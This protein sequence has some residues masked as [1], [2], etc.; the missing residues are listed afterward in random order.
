MAVAGLLAG[1]GVAIPVGAIGALLISLTVR[2]SLRVGVAAGFGVAT[3]D[4]GYALVAVLFGGALGDVLA[5]VAG[6]M[7]WAAAV[8]LVVI[9]ARTAVVA[10]RPVSSVDSRVVTPGRAYLTLVGLTALNPATIV[11]FGALVL[12]GQASGSSGSPGASGP[13]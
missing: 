3:V 8:V 12:G 10:L 1:Y 2:T 6:P 7:R 9:A 11:Y 4:G 5:R 13:L